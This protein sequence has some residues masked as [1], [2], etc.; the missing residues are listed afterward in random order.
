M[1]NTLIQPT[2]LD[3]N[4]TNINKDVELRIIQYNKSK[5]KKEIEI[6]RNKKKIELNDESYKLTKEEKELISI[7]IINSNDTKQLRDKLYGTIKKEKENYLQLRSDLYGLNQI[8]KTNL[9][10]YILLEKSKLYSYDKLPK[11]ND[12]LINSLKYSDIY[13]ELIKNKQQIIN[14]DFKLIDSNNPKKLEDLKYQ[15]LNYIL[16]IKDMYSIDKD[17]DDI[18]L[19]EKYEYHTNID[20]ANELAEILKQTVIYGDNHTN[21]LNEFINAEN[22]NFDFSIDNLI[23][24][25]IITNKFLSILFSK[26]YISTNEVTCFENMFDNT[27]TNKDI[28]MTRT[29]GELLLEITNPENVDIE[30]GKRQQIYM[31]YDGTRPLKDEN[32]KWNGLQIFDLDLKEWINSGGNIDELKQLIHNMLIDFNWYLWICKSSSGNGLHIYTKVA[33]PFH[34]FTDIKNNEYISKYVHRVNY[35]PKRQVI[36]DILFRLHKIKNNTIKFKI[37]DYGYP[38]DDN[39]QPTGMNFNNKYL[40]NVVSRITAGIRLS[41]DLQPLINLNFVDL[42]IGFNLL[43]TVDG[44]SESN[45]N[46]IFDIKTDDKFYNNILNDINENLAIENYTEWLNGKKAAKDSEIDLSKYEGLLNLSTDLD[47][48]KALP[49]NNINYV[50]RYNICNTLAALFGKDGLPLAHIIL[51]SAGSKNIGEINSFYSCAISNRK[52][53]TKLG[54]EILKKHG[55]IKSVKEEL[56]QEITKS[57]KNDLTDKIRQVLVNDSLEYNYHLGENQY[58]SDL[59]DNLEQDISGEYVNFIMSPA[60]SGKCLGYGTEVLMYDGSTKQVQDIKVGE[61]LMG[62]DSKPRNVLS[63]CTGEEELIKIIPNKGEPWICNKSHILSVIHTG[64]WKSEFL[65]NSYDIKDFNVMKFHNQTTKNEY[66]LFKVPLSF[67]EQKVFIHPYWL[68][69]W[70]GD[71]SSNN[72]GIACCDKDAE[73]LLPFLNEYAKVLKMDLVRYEDKREDKTI[74]VYAITKKEK[75]KH[76]N[77]LKEA[78][79]YYNLLNNKHIPKQYLLN[80]RKIRLQ[81]LAGLIDSD[82]GGSNG[83][84]DYITKIPELAENIKFLC[85]SL[86]FMVN[87]KEKEVKG[88]IYQRLL[89]SGDFSEVPIKYER[90]KFVR[91][92]NKNPL[93]YGFKTESIGIGK[94]Y[95]FEI[96]G[97]KRFMLGDFTVTHNTNFILN[98]ARQGKKIMLVLPYISIIQNKVESDKELRKHFDIFY[99]TADIRN[100]T[101]G[102]NIVTTFDKLSRANYEKISR[103]FD[104]IFIDEEHLIYISSYRI[105]TTSNVI[106]KIK[107]LYYISNND[108]YAAKIVM[109]TGTPIGHEQFFSKVKNVITVNKK[110]HKKTMEF[111]I[112]DDSLDALTRLSVK[113]VELLKDN[114]V[115]M[116]PTNKG[117]LYSEKLIGQI[118]YLLQRPV[119]YGYYKRSNIEQEICRLINEE[120]TVGDYEIIFCSNYLS[121]GVDINDKD[122]KFASLYLGNFSGYEIE[123]FNARIRKEAIRSIYCI[124]TQKQDGS[125]KDELLYEPDL[126]LRITDDEAQQFV[127]DKQIA[128]AKNEF[129]ATYDPILRKITTPGFSILNGK[130]AFNL[131]EYE[132]VTFESK[133]ATC[134]E[135][136]I[137]VA[138]ELAKYGYEITISE[139]FDGL[140]KEEQERIKKI[141]IE[142]M[143]QEKQ[144]KHN[145]LIGTFIDLVRKNNYQNEHGLEYFNLIDWISK[146]PDKVIEDRLL[147]DDENLDENG[148]PKEIY[149]KPIYDVFATPVE[150]IVKSKESLEKM[151]KYAK[152]LMKRYSDVKAINIIMEYVDENGILKQK[153][154]QRAINLLKLI[155]SSEANELSEPISKALNKMYQFVDGFESDKNKRIGYETYQ[156]TLDNWVNEYVDD[157]GIKI[158]TK[159]AY[160]KI[161]DGLSEMLSDLST[162]QTS[163][164]GIRFMYNKLPEQDSSLIL[165]RRSIDSLVTNMFKVTENIIQNKNKIKDK[166]IILEKQEF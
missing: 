116:I 88:K 54:I 93:M 75:T 25:K 3:I 65:P 15:A 84:I 100:L 103:M 49:K 72:T 159:Y 86:G 60:G 135:H 35:V 18:E 126:V 144:R 48:I 74:S 122:K 40:D 58:L 160:D 92:I 149:I 164:N 166:H 104:Y 136:P 98:L 47:E 42:P 156:T 31:T 30:K 140:S 29:L 108:P 50:T 123:Q 68:G 53:P 63:T 150:V 97:D 24:N 128:S 21:Y 94:Y 87:H 36:N 39:N 110:S 10:E 33:P 89:I 158:T 145:L 102:R 37:P 83:T 95:G 134:M 109:L 44:I 41:F 163:K 70:L 124:P 157:L 107:D 152:F 64:N 13:H 129:L 59:Q 162:R 130:I 91:N 4:E 5:I 73:I 51:D 34:I 78:L 67:P 7:E 11:F 57:Y 85:R 90:K 115:L 113:A 66:K 155:D 125:I 77:K 82:G 12:L 22:K 111:L 133:Y 14:D 147:C 9:Q 20:Y 142:S 17:I 119:K 121:V 118:E 55:I 81:I 19:F 79:R 153:Y 165:N 148:L 141:G 32:Y 106:K 96:D 132:L 28:Y 38:L 69:Y 52:E 127:D 26:D 131:E 16:K 8:N 146:N 161:K 120:T 6:Y 62:W 137:K 138:R 80:S 61:Q 114:Y 46:R 154:F 151:L 27:Q 56:V 112:C 117:E 105:D 139:E 45:I 1:I 2:E 23:T 43:K 99:G 101:D 71:G 76:L 143:H